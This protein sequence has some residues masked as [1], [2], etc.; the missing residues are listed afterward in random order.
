[1]TSLPL[2]RKSSGSIGESYTSS[3]RAL[4]ELVDNAWDAEAR[5]VKITLPV[6]IYHCPWL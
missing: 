3:E 1:M 5:V 6:M 4:R 2:F